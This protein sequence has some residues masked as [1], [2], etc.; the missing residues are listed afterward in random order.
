MAI[1]FCDAT[2]AEVVARVA[3]QLVV[4]EYRNHK[5]ELERAQTAVQL[6]YKHDLVK[7]S[8]DFRIA[9]SSMYQATVSSNRRSREWLDETIRRARSGLLFRAVFYPAYKATRRDPRVTNRGVRH[10]GAPAPT[11]AYN[12]PGLQVNSYE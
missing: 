10:R 8:L 5:A 4:I 3:Y 12:E 1:P 7:N 9:L 2:R 11:D 6:P